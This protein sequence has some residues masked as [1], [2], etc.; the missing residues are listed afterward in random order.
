MSIKTATARL[1]VVSNSL[2]IALKLVTGIATGSVSILSEAIHSLFDLIAA[3]IAFFSVRLAEQPPDADH[4]YGHGKVEGI[5]GFIEAILIFGAAGLILYEAVHKII[6]GTEVL[7]PVAGIAVMA[8][9]AV[10][11]IFVS[12]R[13]YRVARETGSLALEADA[14]HLKT[15]VYTSAGVA[16]GLFLLWLTDIHLFDPL[17]AIAVALLILYE[18]WQMTKKSLAPLIDRRLSDNELSAIRTAIAKHT[19]DYVGFHEMRTRSSGNT[20][21]IDLHLE[22]PRHLTVEESHR[23]CDAIEKEV[24]SSLPRAEVT[25][26][27]EPCDPAACVTCTHRT[28]SCGVPAGYAD[29][30]EE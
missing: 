29:D 28:I 17:L 23:I 3:V 19:T 10:V 6:E 2:L 20:Q 7:F 9:S 1:S 16:A 24:A 18:S 12:R 30:H 21:Y 5:S 11:N 14:L 25:I 4:P 15:D 26:H 22:M 27:V 8:T 13:L